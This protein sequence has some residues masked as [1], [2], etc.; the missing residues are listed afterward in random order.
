MASSVFMNLK[1]SLE[2]LPHW[3]RAVLLP[4]TEMGCN[5]TT[6]QRRSTALPRGITVTDR[7]PGNDYRQGSSISTFYQA[8]EVPKKKSLEGKGKFNVGC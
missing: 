8:N 4:W 7:A 3:A 5:T 1:Q 6:L 2:S